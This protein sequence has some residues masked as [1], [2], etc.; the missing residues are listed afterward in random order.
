MKCPYCDKPLKVMKFSDTFTCLNPE[1]KQTLGMI[2]TQLMWEK[3]A[4]LHKIRKAAGRYQ[5]ANR[6][7]IN[8]QALAR[9]YRNKNKGGQ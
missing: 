1:C 5:K 7:K 9:Y 3:V 8:A 2:G 6:K 4:S